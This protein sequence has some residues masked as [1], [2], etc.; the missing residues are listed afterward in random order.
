MRRCLAF[1]LA[2]AAA[3]AVAAGA[4]AAEAIQLEGPLV[5]GALVV[6]RLPPGARVAIDGRAIRVSPEGLFLLGFGRDAAPEA[7]LAVTFADGQVARRTLAVARRSYPVERIDGLPERQVTPSA[8]D[9]A[10]I[11]A[12][13][14]LIAQARTRDGAFVGFA[15]GL[16]WPVAGRIG[17]TFGNQRILNGSARQPHAGVDIS[18]AEG[19]PVR[20]AADGE[21]ALAADDFFFTGKTVI[22][23][24][25]HGLA[26]VYAHMSAILVRVGDRVAKGDPIGRVGASGR[27]T[28]PHLHWGVSLF[29][30]LL[31]PE[32]A[33]GP[34]PAGGG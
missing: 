26:T 13:A 4:L 29:D 12:G 33:A 23:D 18:A 24:H 8:E 21:V 1:A 25:G 27:A 16:S 10:R 14:L 5:Q 11:R 20:A 17:G 7:H 9:L 3:F 34:P 22:V 32:L 31:D 6:G 28:G 2:L 15:S 30:T 19:T